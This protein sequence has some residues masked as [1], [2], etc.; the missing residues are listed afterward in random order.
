MLR[1][2][3]DYADQGRGKNEVGCG[4]W[5]GAWLTQERQGDEGGRQAGMMGRM[6]GEVAPGFLPYSATSVPYCFRES[7]VM[8]HLQ[9]LT[10]YPSLNTR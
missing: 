10:S 5:V 6:N 8:P 7:T 3:K 9:A 4:G 1:R 2:W